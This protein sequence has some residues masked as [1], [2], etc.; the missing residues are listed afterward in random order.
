MTSAMIHEKLALTATITPSRTAIHSA[1]MNRRLANH[2]PAL[3]WPCS[4][5]AW[6]LTWSNVPRRHGNSDSAAGREGAACG[7]RGGLG[8]EEA[9]DGGTGA[10]DVRPERAEGEQLRRERRR[11][12]V[13]RRERGEMTRPPDAG[14]RVEQSGPAVDE[15][16]LP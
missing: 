10:G 7:P 6:S 9:V 11:R 2:R 12:E 15:T 16:G 8:M 3:L 13:V 5:I 14:E 4:T 1:M